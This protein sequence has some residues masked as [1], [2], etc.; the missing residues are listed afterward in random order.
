LL[1]RTC[2][3]TGVACEFC[4]ASFYP[5]AARVCVPQYISGRNIFDPIETD[6]PLSGWALALVIIAALIAAC[7]LVGA[8]VTAWNWLVHGVPPKTQLATARKLLRSWWEARVLVRVRALL[9]RV[10]GPAGKQAGV[11]KKYLLG[12]AVEL[13]AAGGGGGLKTK[14]QFTTHDGALHEVGTG[15]CC[16]GICVVASLKMASCQHRLRWSGA[17]QT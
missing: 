11:S 6:P 1:L 10:R 15:S 12:D 8:A 14:G 3:Y 4:L 5:T 2:R 16:A 17:P 9:R 7:I 13:T